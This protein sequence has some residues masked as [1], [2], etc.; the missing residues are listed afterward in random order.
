V[1]V[2]QVDGAGEI[3]WPWIAA[4]AAGAE[5][6]TPDIVSIAKEGADLPPPM[7]EIA[8]RNSSSAKD[9]KS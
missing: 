9:G 7:I 1:V 4:E 8:E 2:E 6:R 5:E 3:R